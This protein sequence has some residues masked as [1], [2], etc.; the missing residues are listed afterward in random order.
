MFHVIGILPEVID[1][2][3][4][5]EYLEYKAVGLA[6]RNSPPAENLRNLLIAFYHDEWIGNSPADSLNPRHFF[7]VAAPSGTGKT[8]TA[9]TLKS[10]GDFVVAHIVLNIPL[11]NGSPYAKNMQPIYQHASILLPSL[12]LNEAIGWDLNEIDALNI[13]VSNDATWTPAVEDLLPGGICEK[14]QLHTVMALSRMFN[15][16]DKD[17]E[18]IVVAKDMRARLW[19]YVGARTRASDRNTF[20]LPVV[21]VDEALSYKDPDSTRRSSFLCAVLRAV[22]IASLFVGT[23]VEILKPPVPRE[24]PCPA[25]VIPTPWARLIT[26]LPRTHYAGT[27]FEILNVRG[28]RATLNFLRAL[29][30][31]AFTCTN[32]VQCFNALFSYRLW[33]YFLKDPTRTIDELRS[34]AAQHLYGEKRLLRTAA[35]VS[36]QL[37]YCLGETLGPEDEDF[38]H[39]HFARLEEEVDLNL[40]PGN[41]VVVK[42]TNKEWVP[43]LAFASPAVD[44]IGPLL[45]GGICTGRKHPAPFTLYTPVSI[46]RLTAAMAVQLCRK[47]LRKVHVGSNITEV[48]STSYPHNFQE[49]SMAAAAVCASQAW[50]ISGV[51]AREFLLHF[52]AELLP[53]VPTQSLRWD[54]ATPLE[55]WWS[56]ADRLVPFCPGIS[57][58]AY[59]TSILPNIGRYERHAHRGGREGVHGMLRDS[60]QTALCTFE[61]VPIATEENGDSSDACMPL[62]AAVTNFISHSSA[63]LGVVVVSS[64]ADSATACGA[65]SNTNVVK[66]VVDQEKETVSIATIGTTDR[67]DTTKKSRIVCIFELI[68]K[69]VT[70]PEDSST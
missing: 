39:C 10:Y 53:S 42:G 20:P 5:G 21:V 44:P 58:E 52:A 1:K 31:Y 48:S 68:F 36:A 63:S 40:T 30:E 64:F 65:R 8:Q 60:N 26:L 2:E 6:L 3:F 45:L 23:N 66:L 69:C 50:G 9:F 35:G 27:L 70:G 34:K 38:I 29:T 18:H 62:R 56:G 11:L 57:T 12:Y 25:R 14:W 43:Q 32:S 24:L 41:Q 13:P 22:G 19:E 16:L 28:K 15:L 47:R 7:C 61:S 17:E 37:Q 4:D 49:S 51:R 55:K 46:I 54:P 67:V 59:L 33:E